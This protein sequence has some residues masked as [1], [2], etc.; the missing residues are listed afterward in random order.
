[1]EWS[2]YLNSTDRRFQK[3]EDSISFMRN[4]ISSELYNYK[5][6]ILDYIRNNQQSQIYQCTCHSEID[7]V[8][9]IVG[10]MLGW[11]EYPESHPYEDKDYL[12]TTEDGNVEIRMWFG[13]KWENGASEV[14]AWKPRPTPYVK[15]KKDSIW[16]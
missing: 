14:I 7:N 1:M 4:A 16:D 6:E 8:I 10:E 2:E 3:I 15:E 11:Y 12:V 13:D 5:N 9:R